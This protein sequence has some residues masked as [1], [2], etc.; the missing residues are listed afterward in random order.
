LAVKGS[1]RSN[2]FAPQGNETENHAS[3][4][5]KSGGCRLRRDRG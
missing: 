5:G 3:S 2:F 4:L 1:L